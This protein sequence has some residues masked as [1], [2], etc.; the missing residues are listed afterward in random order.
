MDLDGVDGHV[1]YP[2]MLRN[3]LRDCVNPEVRAAVARAYNHWIVSF[4]HYSS[5]RFVGLAL[6]PPL[7]DGP[8]VTDILQEARELGLRGAFL[9]LGRGSKPLHHPDFEQFWARAAELRM[10]IS[11]HLDSGVLPFD[12]A[13]SE[14]YKRLPGTAEAHRSLAGVALGQHLGHLIFGGVFDRHAG[15]RIVLAESGV[16]WI[17]YLLERWDDLW[18]HT[19]GAGRTK[20]SRPPSE[21]ANQQIFA[22]FQRDKVGVEMRHV[23]G[24]DNM[25]W[26]SD[27][28]HM[29]GTFPES[30]KVLD[31]LFGG[32][33][34]ADTSKLVYGNVAKLYELE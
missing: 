13:M 30:K 2:Q 6:L 14:E 18:D 28:P 33:P 22:T 34:D 11:L 17:P 23:W 3:G 21:I 9:V 10:P 8:E 25:M 29:M 19:R 12:L 5:T 16:G 26:A 1:L 27:Y 7:D 15:L 31:D 20:N 4:D 24:A 32:L